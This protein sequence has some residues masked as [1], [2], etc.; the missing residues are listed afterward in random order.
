MKTYILP[1][2]CIIPIIFIVTIIVIVLYIYETLIYL[3][4]LAQ[5]KIIKKSVILFR[6]FNMTIWCK[7]FHRLEQQKF[8]IFCAAHSPVRLDIGLETK[9]PYF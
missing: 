8:V 4:G 3:K 2:N 7:H 1:I 9:F 5:A 6:L